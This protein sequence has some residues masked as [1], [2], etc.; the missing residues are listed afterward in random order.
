[1]KTKELILQSIQSIKA[2]LLRTSLT[3]LII[4]IGI[5]ALVGILS[6][7]DAIKSSITNQFS[8]LGAN[9]FSIVEK[10][11]T[12]KKHGNISRKTIGSPITY[13]Q[14][15]LFKELYQLPGTSPNSTYTPVNPNALVSVSSDVLFNAKLRYQSKT[16]NP[17]IE[18]KGVDENYLFVSGYELEK[19]RWFSSIDANKNLYYAV[20]GKDVEALLFPKENALGK[21]IWWGNYQYIIIGVL[22]SK[23]NS[24]AFGG[25]KVMFIPLKNARFVNPSKSPSFNIQVKITSPQTLTYAIEKARVVFRN[26]RKLSVSEDDNFS[27]EKSDV[28]ANLV[29]DDLKKVTLGATFIAAITL[30]GA[31][32]GLLNIMLVNVKERTREIGIRKALGAS[33]KNIQQQFLLESIFIGLSGGIIGIILGILIGNLVALGMNTSF[34]IPWFWISIAVLLC[35][36]VG[37]LSGYYPSKQ[38]AQIDPIESLRY[39]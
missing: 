1:M 9:S 24:F 6:A 14:A 21:K 13:H 32:I 17:N 26:V 11:E 37:V 7:I 39:E 19:G 25:D 30:T 16:T 33:S 36:I 4:A 22:K 34:F 15:K 23:G 8:E 3:M 29:I 38:A 27:I 10:T 2:H 31:V 35:F 28:L 18:L 20:I 5:M 12:I